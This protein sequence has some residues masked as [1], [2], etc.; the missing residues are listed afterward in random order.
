[1]TDV[2][3]RAMLTAMGV[4]FGLLAAPAAPPAGSAAAALCCARVSPCPLP[5]ERRRIP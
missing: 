4:G 1:M 3:R 2:S 5:S